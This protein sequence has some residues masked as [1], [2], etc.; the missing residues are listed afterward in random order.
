MVR[1]K[2]EFLC[3][4]HRLPS[5]DFLPLSFAVAQRCSKD[6]PSE[7]KVTSEVIGQ[8]LL[9]LLHQGHQNLSSA[10]SSLPQF[11][12]NTLSAYMATTYK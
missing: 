1:P 2:R 11:S 4:R 9:C 5:F 6:R 3:L 8:E 7:I 10:Q 12:L